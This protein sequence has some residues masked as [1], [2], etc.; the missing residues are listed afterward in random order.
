[1]ASNLTC[2]INV[3]EK[4]SYVLEI[5]CKAYMYKNKSL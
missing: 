5:E 3:Q 4:F 1:M 2:V